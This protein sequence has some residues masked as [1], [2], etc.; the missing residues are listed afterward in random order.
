MATRLTRYGLETISGQ[1]HRS[2]VEWT[3]IFADE[4]EAQFDALMVEVQDE[5][6]AQARVLAGSVR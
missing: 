4:F 2:S 3:V 6:L 1:T 5:L